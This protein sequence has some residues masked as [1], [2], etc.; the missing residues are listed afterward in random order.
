MNL[1][2]YEGV[3]EYLEEFKDKVSK[4]KV[5]FEVYVCSICS[6]VC[7]CLIVF[8]FYLMGWRYVVK[9]KKYVEVMLSIFFG[10]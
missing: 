2:D 1:G 8:E 10:F 9:V 4:D 3:I 7:V 6:V 5:E